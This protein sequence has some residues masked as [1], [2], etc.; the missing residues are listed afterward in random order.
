MSNRVRSTIGLRVEGFRARH[1]SLETADRQHEGADRQFKS[2]D[3]QRCQMQ[4]TGRFVKKGRFAMAES[5]SNR[6]Q[7][8]SK[9]IAR[10]VAPAFDAVITIRCYKALAKPEDS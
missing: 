1:G 6:R 5:M 8:L 2:V 9:S 4:S 7:P 10:V 3:R